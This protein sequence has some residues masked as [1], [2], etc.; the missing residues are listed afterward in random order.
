MGILQVTTL[1]VA[2]LA[3]ICTALN[4]LPQQDKS[5]AVVGLKIERSRNQP[6]KSLRRRQ[7]VSVDL[8]NDVGILSRFRK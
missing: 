2:I 7:S 4:L 3:P 5:T 1:A 6:L 8:D